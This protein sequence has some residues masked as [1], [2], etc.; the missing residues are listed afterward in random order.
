MTTSADTLGVKR[1]EPQSS[2][3]VTQLP[4]LF[5]VAVFVN[6]V[7][8]FS[9]EPMF[10]KLLLPYLG[11]APSVWNTCLVF[12][13][14]ALLAGYCYAHFS[15]RLL[16]PRLHPPAHIGLLVLSSLALPLQLRMHGEP[17]V[18][19]LGILWILAL[20]L[21]SLGPTF[22]M[23][24][25]GALVAQRW[26]ADSGH[27][28]A[29]N[30][31]F[32]YAA[33]NV[34]SLIAL[35]SYPLV[36]EFWLP[37]STQRAVWS[38]AY[39]A[40]IVI[41]A[42]C[43]WAATK[44][45]HKE[46]PGASASAISQYVVRPAE[47]AR[48]VLYA[49]VPS[50]LLVAVTTYLS[51]DVAAVPLLWVLPLAAYLLTFALVFATRPVLQPSW[52]LK[53][54]TYLL[55]IAAIPLL[56][57]FRVPELPGVALQL[58]L[59]FVVAMVCHAEL[60]RVRPPPEHVTE[61]FVWVSVGGLIGGI[62]T[63]LV[64]P[65]LFDTVLEYPVVLTLAALLRPESNSTPRARSLDFIL[66]LLVGGAIIFLRRHAWAS[67]PLDLMPVTICV[68]IVLFSFRNRPLRFALALGL[69]FIA[70]HTGAATGEMKQ[71]Y[72]QRSFFGVYRV[73]ENAAG[74]ERTLSHGTTIH[75]AQ[76]Q[77]AGQRLVPLT[78]YHPSGPAG[79][80][81]TLTAA[82]QLPQRRAAIVGLGTGA[83]A[84]YGRKGEQWTFYEID[85]LV[86]SIARDPAL[87]TFLRDCPPSV[88]IVLGDA[89]LMIA[90][91]DRRQYD[92]LVLDAFSSDAI[93][94]HLLTRE[95]LRQYVAV[96][97]PGGVIA[98]HISN[99]HLDLEPVISELALDGDLVAR[100]RRDPGAPQGSGGTGQYPSNWVVLS[101]ADEDLG[102]I[103][104]DS[105]WKRLRRRGDLTVWTDDFSNILRVFQW[106]WRG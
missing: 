100:I 97:A 50:S 66:A 70:G 88:D 55:V 48:W 89:R 94:L 42:L 41:V 79:D 78:Y 47:R 12:F 23:L 60:V 99:R 91:A 9:V 19:A 27:P 25:S 75:G 29:E 64:A 21:V 8:L 26:L 73:E 59:L 2:A 3:G 38:A 46:R 14:A 24:A 67:A 40:L 13:Q 98:I 34:G 31:Y 18:G 52:M 51:T 54:E 62:F 104:T 61:F 103:G 22:V 57:D 71:L 63:A 105:R 53:A 11:G 96:T 92:I 82:G 58:S 86:A 10:S 65:V 84:C 95:A 37:L 72:V 43:A 93:P 16:G 6:A 1:I 30:P 7:L 69:L 106:G 76:S 81:F 15:T 5:V 83:L 33:S 74:N 32:L 77:I 101:R 4:V 85:P 87:F 35:L 68:G 56:W 49:A 44:G 36:I 17:P 90:H 39:C 28:Q 20:L 80:V 102:K 45:G